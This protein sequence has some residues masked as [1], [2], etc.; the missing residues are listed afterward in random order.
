[1]S[2]CLASRRPAP[3]VLSVALAAALAVASLARAP[4]GD[5]PGAPEALP[6]TILDE[7]RPTDAAG[8]LTTAERLRVT[9][10]GGNPIFALDWLAAD[11]ELAGDR[12]LPPRPRLPLP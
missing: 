11:L 10:L 9:L 3:V 5:V 6:A 12:T 4:A 8:R 7:Q 1:M 2:T